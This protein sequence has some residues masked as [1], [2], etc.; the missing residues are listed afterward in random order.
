METNINLNTDKN[1][2]EEFE[3]ENMY[4]DS[5]NWRRF[6]NYIID[7]IMIG[8]IQFGVVSLFGLF[9]SSTSSGS[10]DNIYQDNMT[11]KLMDYL[12]QFIFTI[13]Y[14]SIFESLTGRTLGKYITKTKVIHVETGDKP[15][16]YEAL[17]RS[18]CRFIPFEP[19]SFFG[20]GEGGWHDSISKTRVVNLPD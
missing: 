2:F 8:I 13:I 16:F 5:G 7:S 1:G 19:F 11:T 3:D 6:A 17:I 15:T 4:T 18:L 14:Y 10:I 20:S 9:I 12:L